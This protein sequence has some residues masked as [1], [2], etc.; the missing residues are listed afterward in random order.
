MDEL[1]DGF[2]ISLV[3]TA[4]APRLLAE[5]ADGFPLGCMTGKVRICLIG[6]VGI[7]PYMSHLHLPLLNTMGVSFLSEN[8]KTNGQSEVS[9]TLV[10]CIRGVL[11]NKRGCTAP[12]WMI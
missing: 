3:L 10:F 7:L 11:R 1:I 5:D 8:R 12:V 2:V 9:S 6:V 4:H